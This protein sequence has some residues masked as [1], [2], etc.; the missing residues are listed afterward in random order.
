M[1]NLEQENGY[2][3]HWGTNQKHQIETG[4]KLE[5]FAIMSQAIYLFYVG[6]SKW[7]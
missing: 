5:M 2:S 1:G 6:E 3:L 4:E 7:V